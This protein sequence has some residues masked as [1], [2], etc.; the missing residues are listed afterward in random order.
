M[1]AVEETTR[2]R[3]AT[4]LVAIIALAVLASVAGAQAAYPER[5]VRIIVPFPA[6][7]TT[8]IVARIVGQRLT[9]RLGQPFV[10]DNRSGASG[11]IG[12]QAAVSAAPDGQTLLLATPAQAINVSYYQNLPFDFARD[13]TAI[14]LVATTPNVMAV[15]PSVP[16]TNLS[17]LLALVRAKPGHYNFGSTSPGGSPHMSGEFLKIMAQVDIV[18]V[19]YRGAAPMLTD[20][21]AGQVQIGFDNLP[22]SLPQIRAGAI[23]AIA[24]TTAARSAT[25]REI[26][27]M[28]ESGLPGYE[29]SGWFGL[30]APAGTP[31]A[32]VELLNKQVVEI[33]AEP[34]TRAKLLDSGA[35]PVGNSAA[36]Y[37][38]FIKAEVA[39][40]A[41][42][43]KDTG[44]TAK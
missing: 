23:R 22:S 29:V 6:G 31:A 28:A 40:W 38:A 3:Q 37:A 41:R 1:S 7:G 25:A 8:D 9:E 36:D 33:V 27:T 4:R 2:T 5:P 42:V 13:F 34:A 15:N 12:T 16:A 32:I 26:P 18:H 11:N 43:V 20:L 44:I 10:V 21:V 17:E 30:A 39:K 19:P 14:S 24:V 35:D